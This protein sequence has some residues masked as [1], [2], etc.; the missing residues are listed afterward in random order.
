[1]T[2]TAWLSS[3]RGCGERS[4]PVSTTMRTA[5][6]TRRIASPA[7]GNAR[8]L[9]GGRACWRRAGG[10]G[11]SG[12]CSELGASGAVAVLSEDRLVQLT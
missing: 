8:A 5:A 7:A 2:A 10:L 4:S 3:V 9:S 11:A 1:M 12:R 6:A